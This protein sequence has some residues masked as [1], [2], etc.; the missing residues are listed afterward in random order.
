M[1][2]QNL[3]RL[4]LLSI[5]LFYSLCCGALTTSPIL[6]QIQPN[7]QSVVPS[8][9]PT[10]RV[11]SNKKK[12]L[13]EAL[14]KSMPAVVTI[15]VM[16]DVVQQTRPN[17]IKEPLLAPQPRSFGSGFFISDQGFI[18]TNAH[19]IHGAKSIL[20]KNHTGNE[21]IGQVVGFDTVSDLAV[22]HT[23]M[24]PDTIIDLNSH[25]DVY[26]GEPVYA[27]GNA[28]DLS[29]SVSYGIVS[30]LHR[31]ISNPLQDFIQTDSAINQGNSGGPLINSQGELVGV[32][33]MIITT[34]G[35]NNGVGFAIPLSIVRSISEQIVEHGNVRPCQLGVHVQNISS[36][37]AQA[38]GSKRNTQGVLISDVM[39]NSPAEKLKLQPKDIITSFNEE[40]IVTASQLAAQVYSL[41]E[42]SLAKVDVLRNGRPLTLSGTLLMPKPETI[43]ETNPFNGTELKSYEALDF[44]GSK[45]R[46]LQINQIQE[47]SPAW[48]AGLYKNDVIIKVGDNRVESLS[49]IKKLT[50]DKPILI[51]I[52][53]NSRTLFMLLK[54][55]TN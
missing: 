39:V 32:N 35:G 41:R 30:A 37:L 7:A 51:E 40:P 36:D 16:H 5:F 29:Q 34:S 9:S 46:G 10:S 52:M 3:Y 8:Q 42:N 53:R 47:N 13:Q 55:I 15:E 54:P 21:A 49:D 19:V 26:I 25:N 31:A 20:I 17:D 2:F 45:I 33:T 43:S 11:D 14:A 23:S 27:I 50:S 22:L 12:N 18:I 38:L 1:R 28:F 44:S 24:K 4:R 6:A 48:I